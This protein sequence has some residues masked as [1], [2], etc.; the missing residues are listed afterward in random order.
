MDYTYFVITPVDN[1]K[2]YKIVDNAKVSMMSYPNHELVSVS[3]ISDGQQHGICAISVND[4][5]HRLI[6]D[7]IVHAILAI[8]NF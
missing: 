1:I 4:N 5:R 2:D 3:D 6:H 7:N 8:H